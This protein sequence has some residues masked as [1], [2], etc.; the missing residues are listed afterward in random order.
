MLQRNDL[1]S[2]KIIDSCLGGGAALLSKFEDVAR[3][4]VYET[5]WNLS[6]RMRQGSTG[7][8]AFAEIWLHKCSGKHIQLIMVLTDR[9]KRHYAGA[10]D[11]DLHR[12]TIARLYWLEDRVLK[13]LMEIMETEHGFYAT[14]VVYEANHEDPR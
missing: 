10:E 11:C 9:D 4:I 3:Q 2:L 5:V 7:G 6:R 13:Q 1:M 14:L 8:D 12:E